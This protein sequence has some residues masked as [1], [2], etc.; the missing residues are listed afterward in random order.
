MTTKYSVLARSTFCVVAVTIAAFMLL[1]G[2]APVAAQEPEPPPAGAAQAETPDIIGGR[3]AT[4]GAWPWQVGLINRMN[5]NTFLGQFCGGTLIAEDWVLTAAHCVDGV[6]GSLVDVLV[7]AHRLSDTGTRVAAAEAYVHPGY[8]PYYLDND[9]ALLRLSVPVTQ[10]PI[11]LFRPI[12]GTDEYDYMRATVIGWGQSSVD[13]WSGTPYPDALREVSLPVVS[14]EQCAA[15]Y[16][17]GITDNMICAGYEPLTKGACYGDSGGPLMVQK[18]DGVWQQIGIVSFGPY[19]CVTYYGAG[20]DVFTRVSRYTSWIDGCIADPD[21]LQCSGADLY[22]PDNSAAEARMLP[23]AGAVEVHTFHEEG[24][25]DWVK[26]DVIAG[27]IYWLQTSHEVTVPIT[28]DTAIWLYD[29]DG[30]TP[31]TYNDSAT[32]PIYYYP[33]FLA[34][35]VIDA[36]DPPV[37]PADMPTMVGDAEIVWRADRTGTIYASVEPIPN[38][39]GQ[40]YGSSVRYRLVVAELRQLFLPSIK[41]TNEPPAAPPAELCF[42][43]FGNPIPCPEAPVAEAPAPTPVP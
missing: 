6:E 23:S 7:G 36:G 17:S 37:Y 42:D 25:Q 11:S 31:I 4:P 34:Q 29:V 43:I 20:Y 10:T 8:D 16:Y 27:N 38:L 30:R 40:D 5:E 24:D 2:A 41:S 39:F 12:S 28:I 22:E 18:S 14:H 33:P 3:E 19:G 35:T 26:F 21:S 13:Y 9:L 15:S 1:L 32:A